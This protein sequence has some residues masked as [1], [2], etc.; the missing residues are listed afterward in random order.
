MKIKPFRAHYPNPDYITSS[1]SFFKGI[2]EAYP[3]YRRSGIYQPVDEEGFY[4][5]QI[6]NSERT[7]LGIVALADIQ[8]Y[9]SGRIKRHENTLADKEQIH[10]NLLL[11]NRSIVKPVLLTHRPVPALDVILRDVVA[12]RPPDFQVRFEA[13][14]Q[15]HAWW[16][17]ADLSIIEQIQYL[18]ASEVVHGY[19]A[20]GHHRSSATLLL[21]NRLANVKDAPIHKGLLSAFFSV[22]EVEIHDFNRIVD[23]FSSM[24]PT[25]FIAALSHIADIEPLAVAAKPNNKFEVTMYLNREWYK[26]TWKQNILDANATRTV[27]LD[28]QILDDEVLRGILGVQDVRTDGRISYFPGITGLNTFT[29]EVH[30]NDHA[31][32]FCLYPVDI[33]EIKMLSDHGEVMPPKSTWFLPRLKNGVLVH[34]F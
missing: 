2:K 7:F 13:D 34:N 27:L 17:V 9:A 26:L 30:K 6:R 16:A 10:L 4:V 11:R 18:F 29:F 24:S 3:E 20:D 25:R 28:A 22:H 15:D 12:A 14:Q 19:I 31:V 32:G 1:D 21:E 33:Q 8:D 5:Y 23:V